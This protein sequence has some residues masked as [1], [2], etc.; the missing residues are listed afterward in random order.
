MDEVLARARQWLRDHS[1]EHEEELLDICRV[2][3]PT[4][5]EVT[6]AAR[7]ARGLSAAGLVGV[8]TDK[9]HNVIGRLP[10]RRGG[11]ARLS[12]SAHLDTVFPADQP[13]EVRREGERIY[14]PGIGDNSAGLAAL[15]TLARALTGAG[16]QPEHDVLF[17]AN[18]GEEGLGDL[19]GMRGF[20][21]DAGPVYGA[22]LRGCLVLD[23]MLGDLTRHGVG[24]VRYRVR[25]TGPGGHS[26]RDAGGPH[27]IHAMAAA[28]TGLRAIPLPDNPRCTLS[29]GLVSGGE[30]INS[31]ASR[32]EM[33]VDVR[34]ETAEGLAAVTGQ[35]EAW[36]PRLARAEHVELEVDVVGNRPA[37]G[38]AWNHPFLEAIRGTVAEGMGLQLHSKSGSTDA[39][40]AFAAGIPAC[41]LGVQSGGGTHTP[42]EWVD[43]TSLPTGLQAAALALA[44]AAAAVAD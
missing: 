10:G 7:V 42:G 30:G 25:L 27:A 36:L 3:S 1:A 23:G 8:T 44:A 39:N 26:W 31:I 13:I 16:W 41:A 4:F 28:I 19:R 15:V 24:S 20:V 6:R 38:L 43:R 5:E 12:T 2:P 29:V 9:L 18:V 32:A 37:G 34:S 35:V 33:W 11:P 17:V 22:D 40:I 14:A 21:A